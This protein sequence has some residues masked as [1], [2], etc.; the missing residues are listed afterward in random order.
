MWPR[1]A[2]SVSVD[3]VDVACIVYRS[4]SRRVTRLHSQCT[5]GGTG[6]CTRYWQFLRLRFG[7]LLCLLFS[8]PLSHCHSPSAPG[9]QSVLAVSV[10]VS[11][12]GRPHSHAFPSRD[13]VGPRMYTV[14]QGTSR[15]PPCVPFTHTRRHSHRPPQPVALRPPQPSPHATP[16]RVSSPTRCHLSLL[17]GSL[18]MSAAPLSPVTSWTELQRLSG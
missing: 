7:I 3:V 16:P 15:A 14:P 10:S 8:S 13:A 4:S 1:R 5:V 11:R 17:A 2:C 6:C 9:S 18:A 12:S